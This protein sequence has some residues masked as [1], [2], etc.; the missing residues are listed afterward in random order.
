MHVDQ[1]LIKLGFDSYKAIKIAVA[2]Q[3]MVKVVN[4]V[5][6]QCQHYN[7]SNDNKALNIIKKE[8][9]K[10]TPASTSKQDD[11]KQNS[12]E[13]KKKLNL[14]KST[15]S[16]IKNIVK[17][18]KNIASFFNEA[19]NNAKKL[20]NEEDVLFKITCCQL[21]LV[22]RYNKTMSALGVAVDSIC[23][24]I[25]LDLAPIIIEIANDFHNWLKA[26]KELIAHGIAV[27][28]KCIGTILHAVSRAIKYIDKI[29]TATIGW[30]NTLTILTAAWIIFNRHL[31]FS[32]IGVVIGLIT[33]LLILFD[34]LMTYL[35]KGD[36]TFGEF[37]KPLVSTVHM[38]H[39]LFNSLPKPIKDCLL[40]LGT[41]IGGLAGL[42][43]GA[44][45]L[46]NVIKLV[47]SS[48][49]I[50][51]GSL[52]TIAS[53]C[54]TVIGPSFSFLISIFKGFTVVALRLASL[55]ISGVAT[56]ITVVASVVKTAFLMM[57]SA[58]KTLTTILIA[59]PILLIIAAIALAAYL[60]YD[61][62][63]AI[64]SFF[65]KLWDDI[66][67]A[68][69]P[70]SAFFKKL[71]AAVIR[72]FYYA[73]DGIVSYYSLLWKG[74]VIVCKWIG[75]LFKNLWTGITNLFSGAI[76]GIITLFDVLWD[77]AVTVVKSIASCFGRIF[78]YICSPFKAAW[79]FVSNFFDSCHEYTNSFV[80]KISKSFLQMGSNLMS[81]LS[82]LGGWG[83]GK[84]TSI[85]DSVSD[86]I[87]GVLSCFGLT[88]DDT[89]NNRNGY[90]TTDIIDFQT[91]AAVSQK[92][93]RKN[94]SN[95]VNQGNINNNIVIN[96][97]D[98]KA[99]VSQASNELIKQI[100][101]ANNNARTAMGVY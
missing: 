90:T 65:S 69:K 12:K 38:L 52:T 100:I 44:I 3:L 48:L 60:I 88:S 85:I 73:I 49:Q 53:V 51:G 36:S 39:D 7:K 76:D 4:N 63:S 23:T 94:I 18:S 92:G 46:F 80:N 77:A 10:K 57:G 8:N 72:I 61:N 9:D 43:L 66:V 87:K 19:I 17:F 86:N 62:W 5:Q 6:Q 98:T 97:Q 22:E 64:E 83:K 21:Y 2:I 81:L 15:L 56:S 14:L 28:V 20:A 33:G 16:V 54:K 11:D 95:T 13:I 84:F 55:L 31:L 74:V 89:K 82:R 70:I 68:F 45:G 35:E 101:D 58:L 1:M 26:N 30:E 27:L 29:I 96:A 50:L 37:W 75:S 40:G 99:A 59:N 67:S 34:D 91:V 78:D 25:A 41:F 42:S 79:K 47:F 71:W 24:K 32:P 93:A